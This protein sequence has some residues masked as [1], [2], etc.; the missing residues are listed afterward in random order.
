MNATLT[1]IDRIAPSR[2]P[3]G[4][5]AGF[6]RWRNLLFLHWPIDAAAAQASL[7]PE[8]ELD[9]FEG[10]AWIGVVPFTMRDVSP[11]WSPSVP[12]ISNFHEL[13]VRTYVVHRGVPGVWFYS[14][15]AAR[16]L[17]VTIARIRWKL[18]YHK[19]RMR[20]AVDEDVVRYE[21]VR[22]WPKPVPA[23]FRAHYERGAPRG[24]A[25]PGTLEHWLVERYVLFAKRE[26]ALFLGRVH[27]EPYPLRGVE[28][29][30]WEGDMLAVNDLPPAQGEPLVHYSDG[31]DVD[32]Y[33]LE[34]TR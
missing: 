24:T 18:P 5:P 22:R 12:G 23:V 11:W 19:A 25:E 28:L 14:L 6:Q 9:T 13:N 21:S 10:R 2:R 7:P 26:E 3:K 8:L 27:H 33:D 20:M 16:S 31:V 1:S 30:S 29:T 34:E 17:A 32:V 15:D 4:R